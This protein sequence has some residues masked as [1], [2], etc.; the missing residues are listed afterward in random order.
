VT[1]KSIS[2]FSCY[3]RNLHVFV[4]P[5]RF[6]FNVQLK[7][8]ILST[9]GQDLLCIM[10]ENIFEANIFN[11]QRKTWRMALLSKHRSYCNKKI[12]AVYFNRTYGAP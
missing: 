1:I 9:G 4:K 10:H 5:R 6:F 3:D 8:E 7:T 11:V 12:M 2:Q